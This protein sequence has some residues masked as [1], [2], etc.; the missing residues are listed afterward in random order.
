MAASSKAWVL[1]PFA[2]YDCGFE[3]L[4]GHECLSLVKCCV[5]FQVE[6]SARVRSLIQRSPVQCGVF[7]CDR[8][9][10]IMRSRPTE[11]HVDIFVVSMFY[12]GTKVAAL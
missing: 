2:W 8:E 10:S 3:S 7:Q 1:R 6:V 11:L 4:R 12:V 5:F 9:S